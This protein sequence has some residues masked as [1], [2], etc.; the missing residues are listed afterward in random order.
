MSSDAS[1]T[2]IEIMS[3]SGKNGLSKGQREGQK[4]IRIGLC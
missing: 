1:F 3:L 4:Y 2:E